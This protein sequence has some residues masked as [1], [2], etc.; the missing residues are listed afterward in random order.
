MTSLSG[1]KDEDVSRMVCKTWL[2][3]GETLEPAGSLQRLIAASAALSTR[4]VCA[5]KQGDA[6][7]DEPGT[8][9]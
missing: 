6:H 3:T 4:L 2:G 9:S 8:K 7:I 5:E 1:L